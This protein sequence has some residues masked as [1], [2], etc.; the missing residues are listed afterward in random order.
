M[1]RD[2]EF[3]RSLNIMD[4]SMLIAIER[5]NAKKRDLHA[6]NKL[7]GLEMNQGFLMSKSRRNTGFSQ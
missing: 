7:G 5:S 6:E 4:Y 3:L 1:R 2:I